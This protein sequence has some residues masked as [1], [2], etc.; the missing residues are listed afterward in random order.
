MPSVYS[1]TDKGGLE[2][3]DVVKEGESYKVTT[4]SL[5]YIAVIHGE[6][7]NVPEKESLPVWILPA[8]GGVLLAAAVVVIVMVRR[9][10]R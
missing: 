10:N 8:G 1:Y 7:G 6:A 5:D 2:K 4:G 3:L 9:R